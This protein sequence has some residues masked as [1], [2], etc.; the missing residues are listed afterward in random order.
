MRRRLE[1]VGCVFSHD[2][3]DSFVLRLPYYSHFPLFTLLFCQLSGDKHV[4]PYLRAGARE[5]P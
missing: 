2:S 5:N 3:S 1:L 4:P